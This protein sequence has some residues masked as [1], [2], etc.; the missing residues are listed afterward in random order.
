MKAKKILAILLASAMVA[1]LTACQSQQAEEAQPAQTEEAQQESTDD[2]AVEEQEET[3]AAETTV[4]NPSIDFAD[5]LFGFIGNDKVINPSADDSLFSMSEFNGSKALLVEGQDSV[6]YVAIQMDKLVGDKISEVASVMVTLGTE[7]EAF[8]AT[9]GNIYSVVAGEKSDVQAWSI[10]KE[11]AN[12]KTFSMDFANAGSLA[13]G[14]YVVVSM[15][16]DVAVADKG[17]AQTKLY[18]LDITFLDA[19][20]NTIEADTSAEFVAA[21]T[22]EDRSNL[23]GISGAVTVALEGS[24][25][26]WAQIGYQDLTDE[27][28]EILSAEDSVV[29]I[30]YSSETGNMWMGLSGEQWLRIGVGDAD[31]SGQGYSYYNNSK[32]IAQIPYDQIASVCGDDPA[33]WDKQIFLE[34]DGAFEVYSVK[35]GHQAKNLVLTGAIDISDIGVT[36]KADGWA[37]L[38]YVDIPE[39]AW[40]ALTTPGSMVA[41]E[42]SSESGDMWMGLSGNQWLRIGVGDADGSGSVDAVTDGSVCYVTYDMIEEVCGEDT[43]AWDKQIFVES[44]T[45]FEVYSV[46]VGKAGE[47]VPNN[48]QIDCEMSTTGADG[49]SQFGE[50]IS[51]EAFEALQKPGSVINISYASESGECW[52]VMPWAAAGWMRV[53]VGNYDGSGQGYAVFNGSTCQ[54][55]HDMIAEYCG[56][57]A[58]TWGNC[59]QVEASTA[60]DVYSVTIGQTE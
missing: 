13:E 54:I 40:T 25:D 60:F 38:G 26:G 31:G 35:I 55:T 27:E 3:A 44:D 18:I 33:K 21:Q 4:T 19:A 30:S 37:Q 22:G 43:S 6:P 36:G 5:D 47:F 24:G 45:A 56:E 51:D 52:V 15:E 2:E 10:Y 17:L 49:W 9:S 59:I 48:R 42:Y 50:G 53:G 8:Y 32:N 57:D 29:E 1:S 28:F 16:S 39:E 14:D 11:S 7:N 46:K 23:F 20:G 41:I 58:S 12:P 34:S